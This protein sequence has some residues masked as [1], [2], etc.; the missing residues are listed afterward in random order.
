MTGSNRFAAL[1]GQIGLGVCGAVLLGGFVLSHAPLPQAEPIKPEETLRIALIKPV[2]PTPTP[3]KVMPVGDLVDG[4]V[5][6][7]MAR[8]PSSNLAPVSWSW[9]DEEPIAPTRAAWR[10]PAET[11]ARVEPPVTKPQYRGRDLAFGFDE[12]RPDFVN[13]RRRRHERMD[14]LAEA[15]A[16]WGREPVRDDR[17]WAREPVEDDRDDYAAEPVEDGREYDEDED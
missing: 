5:H 3:G 1:A 9:E 10:P 15:R 7:T 12:P 14:R 17:R 13:D 11:E 8:E 4:Y 16:R 2:E 6:R